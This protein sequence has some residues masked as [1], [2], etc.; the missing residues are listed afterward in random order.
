MR[1]K[2]TSQSKGPLVTHRRLWPREIRLQVA[3]SIVDRGLRLGDLVDALGISR[4]TLVDWVQRY[5]R[6]GVEG[7]SD[8]PRPRQARKEMNLRREAVIAAKKARPEQGAKRIR[9]ELARY[10]GV[11]VSDTT[12]RRILREEGLLTERPAEKVMPSPRQFERAEPNQLWQSDIF[13]F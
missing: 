5:R 4:N 3:Q 11:G 7:F 12:V 2:D 1:S 9:D 13:T 8:E 6:R 10:G